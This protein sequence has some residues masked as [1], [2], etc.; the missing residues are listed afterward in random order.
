MLAPF[1]NKSVLQLLLP[2]AG[3]LPES[4]R[5]SLQ[6]SSEPPRAL[7]FCTCLFCLICF[8]STTFA[9][10]PNKFTS[11]D[12]LDQIAPVVNV[13]IYGWYEEHFGRGI[14]G[15]RLQSSEIAANEP[16][17]L[18][19]RILRGERAENIRAA[20]I[21]TGLTEFDWRQLRRWGISE[22]RLPSGSVVLFKE[23]T[24]W[25]RYKW[26]VIGAGALL[27][28]QSLLIVFL[29][30]ERRKLQS[31]RK[32]LGKIEERNRAILRAIP[33]LMFF[34]N[35]DGTYLDC[36][37]KDPRL[38]LLPPDQFL[39]KKM[40]EVLPPQLCDQFRVYFK[41][42]HETKET[43]LH[44]YSLP[45]KGELK[46]FEARI[47]ASNGDSLLTIVRDITES[48]RASEALRESESRFATAFNSNPQPMTLT[49]VDAG[50]FIDVNQSFISM[51]GYNR[52][53]LVGRT[54][55]E[56]N[57]WE[58]QGA[59]ADFLRQLNDN[60][61]VHNMEVR[62]RTK[63]GELRVML[64]SAELV[65]LAGHRCALVSSTDITERKQSEQWLS[66]LT[67]Q[68]LK[69]QDEER[70]HIARELHD[71]TAQAIGVILLNL[72]YVNK[73]IPVKDSLTKDKLA[74]SIALGEQALK[75]IR[76]LSY[77]LHP[78]LLDHAGLVTAL[79]WYAKGFT[80]RSGIKVDFAENGD[81]GHRMPPDVEYSLFR[82]VQECLTNIRRHTNSETASIT[83][84]RTEEE[85]VLQVRD[86]G[87][88]L[89]LERSTNGD[90]IESVGVGIQGMRHRLKQLGGELA[91]DSAQTGTTVTATVPVK[92]V[93]Y[94][95]Y[96][97]S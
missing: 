34:Q 42:A 29:L 58:T 97:T 63:S 73:A 89:S 92:W 16:A 31:A 94:D 96:T 93:I 51:I 57:I 24:F 43:Q 81:D 41:Q 9:Q 74:E 40:D 4:R 79:Q 88:G 14:V 71:V 36:H 83:L 10:T 70:R 19:L 72:A 68:L 75:E 86:R 44:E 66:E 13:H 20:Q 15:G 5:S 26:R 12:S 53:E 77:V 18:A 3:L 25:E 65:E 80:E 95:S 67:A 49:T 52:N 85:V 32:A 17:Q 84:T 8:L 69:S 64:L 54:S 56:L 33:D 11:T 48:R 39:G 7:S 78:P 76:T 62:L 50:L 59:R 46:W 47:A 30:I 61:S 38:L 87:I 37:V 82:V 2:I 1:P 27:A 23:P 35:K 91:V 45:I 21:D 22:E 60:G 90:S 28:M 55:L 6:Q